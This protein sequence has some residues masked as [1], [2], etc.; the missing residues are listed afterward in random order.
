MRKPKETTVPNYGTTIS[1]CQF[2]IKPAV[3]ADVIQAALSLSEAIKL[4]AQAVNELAK[5]L[6]NKNAAPVSAI[7]VNPPQTNRGE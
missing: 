7:I 3:N 6:S 4:N 2:E 1:N 5:I